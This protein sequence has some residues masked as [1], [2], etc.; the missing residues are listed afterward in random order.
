MRKVFIGYNRVSTKGQGESGLGLEAQTTATEAFV[1]SCGAKLLASYTEVE[2]GK[3][4]DRPELAKAL[5][6]A[7]LTDG[8]LLIARLD[9]LSRDAHFLLGL[10]K[11]G[12]RFQAVDMPHADNFTVG[13]MALIA[14]KERESISERTK[15][16]LA[17]ARKRIAITGQKNRP[18]V[19]R[20]GNPNGAAG[21]AGRYQKE[22]SAAA[23][24]NADARAKAL[25]PTIADIRAGGV[26]SATGIASELNRREVAAALGGKWTARS[27]L[28]VLARLGG[29][30]ALWHRAG[31]TE[32][33]NAPNVAHR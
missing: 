5:E 24:A 9:R 17:E 3:H 26:I 25:A 15:A 28:N 32:S 29:Q 12:V 21:I 14:Q 10:Q 19:K 18:D 4:T 23:K 20:L 22:A 33:A 8:I 2:S 13:I 11:A 16:A 31:L 30:S 1:T 6:H 27:V 7:R